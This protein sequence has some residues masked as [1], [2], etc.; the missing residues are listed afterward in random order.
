MSTTARKLASVAG[1]LLHYSIC[2]QN[3]RRQNHCVQPALDMIARKDFD[4]RVMATHRFALA[5][6]QAAFELVAGY[7]DGVVKAMIDIG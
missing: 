5:D 2:I 3:V 4:V 1:R 6:A 7:R